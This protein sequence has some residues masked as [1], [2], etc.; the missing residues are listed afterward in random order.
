MELTLMLITYMLDI[1]E[2]LLLHCIILVLSL[3][4][5]NIIL[6]EVLVLQAEQ[7]L[8]NYYFIIRRIL[9]WHLVR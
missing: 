3:Y 6:L 4:R 8:S 1:F 9:T 5:A 7:N 2:A